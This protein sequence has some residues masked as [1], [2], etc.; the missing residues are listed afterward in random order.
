MTIETSK[1]LLKRFQ[2]ESLGIPT[3]QEEVLLKKSSELLRLRLHEGYFFSI[4]P[5][6]EQMANV[7]HKQYPFTGEQ[8]KKIVTTV[9]QH[10]SDILGTLF[11]IY[12]IDVTQKPTEQEEWVMGKLSAEKK[13]SEHDQLQLIQYFL[14]E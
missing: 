14:T 11:Q 10:E 9:A 5:A 12:D 7:F 8:Y 6:L 4:Y 2:I 13:L 1:H 3:K